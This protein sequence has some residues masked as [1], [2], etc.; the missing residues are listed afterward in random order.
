MAEIKIRATNSFA[1]WRAVLVTPL[2]IPP[3]HRCHGTGQD[4][5]SD[6]EYD[7]PCLYCAATGLD[8]PP[9]QVDIQYAAGVRKQVQRWQR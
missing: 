8:E 4:P 7:E 2:P 6:P 9:E 1:G 5:K 3:C